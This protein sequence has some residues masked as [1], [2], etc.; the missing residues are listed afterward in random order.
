M[1][2]NIQKYDSYKYAYDQI[3]AAINAR[4]YLEAITIEESIL[5]DRLYRFF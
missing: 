3:R 4:F 2:K 5:A 1:E